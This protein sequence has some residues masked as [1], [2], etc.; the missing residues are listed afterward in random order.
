MAI[1]VIAEG[2]AVERHWA[3]ECPGC[4]A[5]YEWEDNDAVDINLSTLEGDTS[6]IQCQTV[7]CGKFV[8]GSP[9]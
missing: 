2:E 4:A 9:K 6:R 1:T 5:K 7:G 3:G 8:L